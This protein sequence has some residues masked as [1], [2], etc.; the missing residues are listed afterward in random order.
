M[1]NLL[2]WA[3]S[4]MGGK[5]ID[6]EHIIMQDLVA[7]TIK[8]LKSPADKKN[9]AVNNLISGKVATKADKEGI[10]LVIRNLIWNAIKFTREQGNI[11]VSARTEGKEILF[12]VEDI[13]VGIPENILHKLFNNH[14][15]YT[16]NGTNN[17]KGTGLA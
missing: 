12:T 6:E 15:F 9:I 17:E 4:Q 10:R 16:S 8:M 7:R 5:A 3:K 2:V 1:E 11:D 14:G 13:G